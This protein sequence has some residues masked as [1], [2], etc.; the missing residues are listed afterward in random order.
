MDQAGNMASGLNLEEIGEDG[1]AVANKLWKIAA[2]LKRRSK[3]QAMTEKRGV[4][5]QETRGGNRVDWAGA[6][7][8]EALPELPPDSYPEDAAD[9][10]VLYDDAA[11]ETGDDT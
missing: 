1:Q 8:G 9:L 11:P 4:P 6:K 10:P 2:Y 3:G 5:A 7:P